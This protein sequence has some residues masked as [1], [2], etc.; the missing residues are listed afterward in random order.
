MESARAKKKKKK[1]KKKEDDSKLGSRFTRDGKRA[2]Y[3]KRAAAGTSP[4][5]ERPMQQRHMIVQSS[6]WD[7]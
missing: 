1:K 4:A 7:F 3:L 2:I 6:C 5:T